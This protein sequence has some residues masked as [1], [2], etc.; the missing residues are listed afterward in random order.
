[1]PFAEVDGI[2]LYYE[3]QGQ[4]DPVLLMHHGFGCSKMWNAVVPQLLERGYK[5][6]CYDRKGYGQS[7]LG[8]C[9]YDFYV[10][11]EFRPKSVQELES[12]R[13]WLGIDSFH[14][15]GHCEGGVVAVDYAAKYPHRVKDMV[16]SSTLCYGTVDM[17]DF[18]ASKFTKSFEELDPD[19]RTKFLDWHGERAEELFEQFRRYGGAYGRHFFDLRPTLAFVNCPT[20]VLYPDRSYLFEVEQGVAFYRGLPNGELAVVPDCGHN[21][22]EEQ[23][24]EY[25]AHAVNFLDR[26]RFGAAS[27][28]TGKKSRAI[29]CAG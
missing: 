20:L 6:I 3:I 5:T 21:T 1:M 29:T 4:G 12:L 10:S 19:L 15:V 2:E 9:F 7:Q 23:P 25:A 27:R 8:E 16:I 17:A 28:R 14:I 24:E 26:H 18:N 22:Y 11:D 13:H